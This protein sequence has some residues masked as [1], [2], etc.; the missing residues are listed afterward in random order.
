M[1]LSTANF[2]ALL[3]KATAIYLAAKGASDANSATLGTSGNGIGDT[4]STAWGAYGK[5]SGLETLVLALADYD[6]LQPLLTPTHNILSVTGW[7]NYVR[8]LFSSW[9]TG[10]ETTCSRASSVDASITGIN[11]YATYYNT[12]AGGA[13]NALMCPDFRDIYY[14]TH[15]NTYPTAK[16]VYAP[17]GTSIG[18]YNV[19]TLVLSGNSTVDTTKYAGHA[20][21]TMTVASSAGTYSGTVVIAVSGYNS[22]GTLTTDTWTSP[23]ITGNGSVTITAG[24]TVKVVTQITAVNSVP[25]GM[26]AG[27]LT[28]TGLAPSGRTYPPT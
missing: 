17:P 28:F 15:N 18:S 27:T 21:I 20:R 16:N 1:A 4:S 3:D 2:N 5:A 8:T 10:M 23:T 22:A 13:F 25:A 11:T 7:Q 6:Q 19:A 14:Y 26:T 24:S 9:I 12:G